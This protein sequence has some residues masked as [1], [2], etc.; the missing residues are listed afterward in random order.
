[1]GEK[2][3]K[4]LLFGL[5]YEVKDSITDFILNKDI[6]VLTML[7]YKRGFFEGLFNPSFTKK[8]DADAYCSCSSDAY[9]IKQALFINCFCFN[10]C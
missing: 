8:V 7:T 3:L 5:R 10:D 1:M 9:K 2:N 6:D 4:Q